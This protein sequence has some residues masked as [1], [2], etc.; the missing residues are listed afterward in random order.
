MINP[1]RELA[2]DTLQLLQSTVATDIAAFAGGKLQL[3]S[4]QVTEDAPIVNRTLANVTAEL[5][6]VPILAAAIERDG[7]TLVPDG[8]TVVRSGDQVYVIA[9]IDA[10]DIKFEVQQ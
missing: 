9:T 5:G 2:L 10:L 3:I 7:Q 8:S 6:R 4:L 1:E